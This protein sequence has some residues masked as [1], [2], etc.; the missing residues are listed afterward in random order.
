MAD[1]LKFSVFHLIA[2]IGS[3]IVGLIVGISFV[4][5]VP[6]RA[7]SHLITGFLWVLIIGTAMGLASFVRER[8]ER[9]DLRRGLIIG[10]QI[11][12]PSTTF[13]ML[14]VALGSLNAAEV[15]VMPDGASVVSRPDMLSVAPILYMVTLVIT[16]FI[17]LGYPLTSPFGVKHEA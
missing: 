3:I 14:A 8:I 15:T 1:F 16:L 4:W 9:G 11:I 10:C 17:G 7:W 6:D 12:F 2:Y 5:E 13:Y